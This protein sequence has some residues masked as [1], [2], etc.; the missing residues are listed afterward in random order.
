M[1]NSRTSVLLHA[2]LFSRALCLS[3]G[4]RPVLKGSIP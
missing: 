4:C 1:G 3:Y 2:S